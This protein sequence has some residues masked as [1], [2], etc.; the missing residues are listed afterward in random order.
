MSMLVIW[1]LEVE[2]D[3]RFSNGSYE[4]HPSEA[5][6]RE[7]LADHQAS[8]PPARWRI[9]RQTVTTDHLEQVGTWDDV[10]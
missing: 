8:D 6:A 10:A 2:W 4:R 9:F 1:R 3:R 7:S 5:E